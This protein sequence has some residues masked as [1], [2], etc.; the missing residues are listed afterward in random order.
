VIAALVATAIAVAG[1]SAAASS[2]PEPLAGIGQ[3]QLAGQ[4]VVAGFEGTRVPGSLKRM[5]RKGRLAGV[6]LFADNL[7][8]EDAARTVVG[9]LRSIPRPRPVG[10]PLLVM[11][12][13]EGGAVKRLPGPPSMSAAAMGR[14]GA[15]V[16]RRQGRRTARYLD[17][18]GINVDLAPVLDI[19]HPGGEIAKTGRGFA[20]RAG[21]AGT[22]G[23]AFAGGLRRGGVAATAK[24]FPGFGAA[25][26]NTDDAT[27]VIG[28]SDRRLRRREERPFERFAARSGELVMLS[29][30]IYPALDPGTP[31][32][33]SR[34]IATRELRKRVGYR[35]VS[36]TDAMDAA[37]VRGI[38]APGK[39]ARLAARAGS[40]L[41]LF[42]DVGEARAGTAE[43]VA[44]LRDGSLRRD[45]F[46]A[47]ARR[48]LRLRNSLRD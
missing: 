10:E 36:V 46:R 9:R 40:D 28:L 44:S 39:R 21:R 25:R 37:A 31:A 11:V 15:A 30:A 35:G 4:R 26:A 1:G 43:L 22:A 47:A 20:S 14:G 5:I 7:P 23:G 48:V 24:H 33:L 27:Q 34:R 41:L 3:R 29:W 13:Q 19:A 45:R 17:G 12:D 6:V 8:S 2:A 16:A 32:G 18:F 38:G 42:T